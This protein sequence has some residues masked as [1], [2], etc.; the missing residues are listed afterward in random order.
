M[1][2]VDDFALRKGDSYATILVDLK[3]RR[4]LDV[5]PGRDAAPL[6]TWLRGHPEVEII[7]RDRAGAYAEGA[8][9]GAPQA[10]QVAD[11][12]HLW[13]NLAEAVEKTVGAHHGCIRTA[14]AIRPVAKELVAGGLVTKEPHAVATDPFVPP[15]NP[16][17]RG[18]PTA[19][20]GSHHRALR[21]SAATAGRGEN[22]GRDPP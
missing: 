9:A 18:A 11:G 3:A 8:R 6:A 7:Y 21:G 14:F 20:G 4:P 5:L 22:A 15:R 2:G 1:L 13:S 19:P 16:R 12:W 17:R 10:M